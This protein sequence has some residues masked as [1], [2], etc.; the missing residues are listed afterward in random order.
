MAMPKAFF[1][2][3]PFITKVISSDDARAVRNG[4]HPTFRDYFF[5][6]RM[7]C[8]FS[9][10]QRFTGIIGEYGSSVAIMTKNE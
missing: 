2:S 7:S 8:V 4:Y 10:E 9:I 3:N 1:K 6:F 5:V